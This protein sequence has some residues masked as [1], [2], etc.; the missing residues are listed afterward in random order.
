VREVLERAVLVALDRAHGRAVGD[1]LH[2]IGLST[3]ARE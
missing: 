2:G 1:R 3:I